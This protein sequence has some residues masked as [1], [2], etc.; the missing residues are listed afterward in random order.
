MRSAVVGVLALVVITGCGARKSSLLLERYA[1][2][3]IEDARAVGQPVAWTLEPVVQTKT[4]GGVEVTVNHASAEY[5]KNFFDNEKLFGP[6]AG[7]TPYYPEHLV[8]YVSIA[9]R[10]Q[11]RIRIDPNTFRL[12]DDRGNQLGAIGVDY[13]T[14]LAEYRQPVATTTRGVLEEAKPGY[15]GVGLPIGRLFAKPQWR[16][17]LLK[18]SALQGGDLYPGVTHDGL[19]TFWSPA[20]LAQKLSLVIANVQTDFDPRDEPRQ[21]IEFVFDFEASHP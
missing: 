18:Q 1:R 4:Q 20:P 16:F 9:N 19:I 5:L 8:F 17:A 13:V 12:L 10:S 2:G 11:E 14:A 3:P 15:F 21:S 6:L 7:Q